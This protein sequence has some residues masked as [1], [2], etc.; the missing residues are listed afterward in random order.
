MAAAESGKSVDIP[1]N[2]QRKGN[3]SQIGKGAI[4]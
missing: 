3:Q 2:W 4:L 1:L